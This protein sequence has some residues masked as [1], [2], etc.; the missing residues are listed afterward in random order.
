VPYFCRRAYAEELLLLNSGESL[1][2]HGEEL[3]SYEA[4]DQ[5]HCRTFKNVTAAGLR[6]LVDSSF[7]LA[8]RFP[9][10]VMLEGEV[11]RFDQ[12]LAQYLG[13]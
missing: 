7:F 2:V 3:A 5:A 10:S 12:V 4:Y 1:V 9:D 13:L 6:Q 8:R 11:V